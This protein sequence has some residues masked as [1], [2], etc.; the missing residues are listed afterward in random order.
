[1]AAQP[2]RADTVRAASEIVNS[3]RAGDGE[4]ISETERVSLLQKAKSLAM[5]LEKPEDGLIKM[6]FAGAELMAVRICVDLNIFAILAEKEVTSAKELST[7]TGA[8]EAL[9]R[10]LLRVLTATSIVAEHGAGMYGP[11]PWTEKLCMRTTASMIKFMQGMVA[12]CF[13]HAPKYFAEEGHHNPQDPSNVVFQRAFDAK[14]ITVFPWFMKP[15][16][17]QYW[18]DATG[19]FEC[20][21]GSRPSWVKWFPV[22]EKLLTGLRE[23]GPLLVDVAGGRG[24]DITEFLEQ[25]P[26]VSGRLVLQDLQP[27]L[28]SA[29]LSPRIEKHAINFFEDVPIQGSRLYFMKFIMHDYNDEQCLVIL[30]NVAQAMK[31]GYS[32]LVIN[33]FILPDVGCPELSARWDMSMMTIMGGIERTETQWRSLMDTAGFHVEGLYQP[34][35]DGQG[36]IVLSL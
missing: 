11:T 30:K 34:P 29:T 7:K 5:Q 16:N 36:I 1:M 19:F 33:D 21:R 2:T 35:G 10:R 9:I 18:E 25:F 24:H 8:D 12:P 17:K 31:K 15:E 20:D 23:E 22:R 14:G 27:V 32:Q 3:L 13:N 4:H 6:A 26:D 28:D